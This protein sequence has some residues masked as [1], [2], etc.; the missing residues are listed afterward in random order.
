[1]QSNRFTENVKYYMMLYYGTEN[2]YNSN[3]NGFQSE[4]YIDSSI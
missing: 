2:V 1:M 3:E 4:F